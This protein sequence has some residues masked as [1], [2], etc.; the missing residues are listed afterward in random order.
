MTVDVRKLRMLRHTLLVQRLGGEDKTPG[1]IIIPKDSR[2]VREEG[3][4]LKVGEGTPDNPPPAEK[5]DVVC[6]ERFSGRA[7][8]VDV[9]PDGSRVEVETFVILKFDQVTAVY[10]EAPDYS[11]EYRGGDLSKQ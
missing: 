6:F 10:E 7:L 8:D 1:G 2:R 4:V 11:L 5:G 3:I 9:M